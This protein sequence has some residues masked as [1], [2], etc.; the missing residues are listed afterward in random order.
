MCVCVCDYYIIIKLDLKATNECFREDIS[1]EE[2]K[3]KKN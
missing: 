1:L 3:A 2:G